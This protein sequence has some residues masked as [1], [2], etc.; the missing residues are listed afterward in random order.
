M[1]S[2]KFHT[3]SRHGCNECKHRKVK[4]DEARPSCL[5]CLNRR[6]PCTYTSPFIQD[7]QKEWAS[8]TFL[9]SSA[10]PASTSLAPSNPESP[11]QTFQRLVP[12]F[13]PSPAPAIDAIP[14]TK[15]EDTYRSHDMALLHHYTTNTSMTITRSSALQHIWQ[16][17]IPKLSFSSPYLLHCILALSASHLAQRPPLDSTNSSHH[18]QSLVREHHRAAVSLFRPQLENINPQNGPAIFAFSVLF[19]CLSLSM[20]TPLDSLLSQRDKCKSFIMQMNT[21]IRLIRGI[22]DV[23]LP[24]VPHF[25]ESL[26]HQLLLIEK[27]GH[28][29]PLSF[30]AE[31]II[32]LIEQSV[33]TDPAIVS[34]KDGYTAV[35]QRLR[36]CNPRRD[37]KT[38]QT[39]IVLMWPVALPPFFFD[40][41]EKMRPVALAILA[42]FGVLLHSVS[43]EW[44]IDDIGKKLVKAVAEM[45]PRGWE[46]VTAWAKMNI[47]NPCDYTPAV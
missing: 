27:T 41:V 43:K 21:S 2:R 14:S 30:D 40:E 28:K 10:T 11:S 42:F 37:E 18:Y 13:S 36:Y 16:M 20:P 9:A 12:T 5:R 24:S 25:Q 1:P 32:R 7:Y 4:C 3:K 15:S 31:V 23:S 8:I 44:W 6:A 39:A 34:L 47:R 38:E 33:D 35:L 46:S 26:F 45:L 29:E 19:I 22:H 17:V